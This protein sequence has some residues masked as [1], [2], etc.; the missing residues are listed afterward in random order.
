MKKFEFHIQRFA[1]T[2]TG[3][4]S[5]DYLSNYSDNVMMYAYG[6]ADTI[7]NY[8]DDVTISAG[9][10]NDTVI[11]GL[12]DYNSINAGAGNDVISLSSSQNWGW[13][14]TI[15]A[16]TGDDTIYANSLNSYYGDLYRYMSGDGN[17]IIY[18]FTDKDTIFI[19]GT[20]A[21]RSTVSGNVIL[22][23]ASGGAITLS[24]A[25]SKTFTVIDD[26][27]PL[28]IVNSTSHTVV[29]GTANADTITS[30][31]ASYVTI[32][33]GAGNDTI[34]NIYSGGGDYVSISGGNGDDYI[35]TYYSWHDT[36]SGDAGADTISIDRGRDNLING[37]AG[38]DKISLSN[39]SGAMTISGG[40]GNDTIYGDTVNVYGVLYNYA[41]GDGSD[42]M[43]NVS[44][45]DTISISGVSGENLWST[46]SSGSNVIVNVT[47]GGSMTL[48]GAVGKSLKI[49]PQN[50]GV[51]IVNSKA[52]TVINGTAYGDT[53]SNTGAYTKVYGNGGGDS[54]Y[55]TSASHVTLSGGA[56]NDTIQ[57]IYSGGGDYVS[58]SG[59]NGDDYI[60]TY[61]SWHDTI[62]GDAG[63]D[64]IHVSRGYDNV[65]DGGAG[66]DKISLS[67][68]SGKMT[69]RGGAGNDTIYGDTVNNYGVVYEYSTTSGNDVIY[70]FHANDTLSVN[71]ATYSTSTV[72]NDVLVSITGGGTI[73]LIGAKGIFN[74]G[75]TTFTEG[76]D[77]YSNTTSNTVLSALAGNDT[78][79]NSG[80]KVTL[81]AGTG[82]DKIYNNNGDS[83]SIDAGDGNDSIYAYDNDSV[84]IKAGAGSDTVN[85]SYYSSK[86]YGESGNDLM[87][88][89]GSGIS[90]LIDGGE[91]DDTIL[92]NGGTIYG[93]AGADSIS[94]SSGNYSGRIIN[95]GTGDDTIYGNSLSGY[96]AIYQYKYGDDNDVIKN[97]NAKD[98]ISIAGSSDYTTLKS[99]TNL[100]VS[101]IGSGAMTLSG[102]A[103]TT[104][105][106][107]GGHYIG[108][109]PTDGINVINST[110][111]VTITGTEYGDTIK[112][113][114]NR[115]GDYVVIEAGVGEDTIFNDYG[116]HLT[117]NAGAGDDT[118]TSYRGSS[119]SI[120]AGAGNDVISLS[121]SKGLTVVKGGTGNDIIYGDTVAHVYQYEN[122]DGDDV[123]YGYNAKDT[124]TISGGDYTRSTVGNDVII[125]VTDADSTVVTGSIT[126]SGAKG[127]AINI[128]GYI[129]P[130]PTTLTAQQVIK[131]FMG[132]LD[133]TSYSGI[134]A[135]NQAVS[136]ASNGYFTNAQAA[137]NQMVSDCQNND[138]NTFLQ[139]YCG[140][141]LNNSDTGAIT[142]SDAGGSATKTAT[143][144]VPESGS[145]N[146]FTGSS[147]TTNGLTVQLASYA[148]GNIF[149]PA[150]LSYS[151]LTD[152]TQKYI[153][154]A[155]QTW[156]V[157]G[158]LELISE[159]YG[160]NF[161]FSSDSSA[162][163]KKM[164][165][166]F[167]RK[168][169]GTMAVTGWYSNY[170]GQATQLSMAVNMRNYDTLINGSMD[171]KLSDSDGYYLDRVL[172]HE[173]THAVMVANINYMAD[174]PDFIVEGMAELTHGTDDD[175]ASEISY[176]ANSPTALRN[177]L[178]LYQGSYDSY[179]GG[180]MFLR[181]LAKQSA[182]NAGSDSGNMSA[183]VSSSNN[184]SSSNIT[185]QRD[186]TIKSGVLTAAK[187]FDEDMIDLSTYSSTVTKVNASN[188]TNGVMIIGNTRNNSIKAGKG[189]DTISGNT[190]NDSIFGGNGNDVIYGD[191]GNDVIKGEAGNDTLSGG[192]GK[193]TLYGGAG[194][195]VFVHLAENDFIADYVAGQDKIKLVEG[196]ILSASVSGSNIVLGTSTG[197]IT[198]K[199]GKGK[200]ITVIDEE[201]NET[202]QIYTNNFGSEGSSDSAPTGVSVKSGILTAN[203]TFTGS[204]ID[205]TATYASTVTKVNATAL[206][207][208]VN[209]IGNSSANSI[210]S[211]KG[212]D[213]I[214]GAA[215]KD[216]I[217]GGAGNDVLYG[218]ADNDILKGEAG[219]DTLYGGAGNDTL[220]G[221]AGNDVFVYESGNDYIADYAVGDKIKLVDSAITSSSISGSNV[222]LTVDSGTITLKGGKGKNVTVIDSDGNS[223]TRKYTNETFDRASSADLFEDSNF[224]T[225][226]TKLEDITAISADNYSAGK[227]ETVNYGT[228]AQD[229]NQ[230]YITYSSNK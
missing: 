142:G 18:G 87:S 115:G 154:Q 159:S 216:S 179:A 182:E 106:V 140:I 107:K 136:V 202:T 181:Y 60:Y 193:D 203:K 113:I 188:L 218:G 38:N 171:G 195:D 185:S 44:A 47:G 164:Y 217:L 62:S 219:A 89:S 34:Q 222:I 1:T 7:Y 22:N 65:I 81:N 13:R 197:S 174:L 66:D 97:Y 48:V 17:D 50:I 208:A 23:M 215:G 161:G 24:G 67:S 84:T 95:G 30:S 152:N 130:E 74:P 138:S 94:L 128:N 204:T 86:I 78:I 46:V 134:A 141:I 32:S 127:K 170:T 223:T 71:G 56:G 207:Q 206:S 53:I 35:Y 176:L 14:T 99:G 39:N 105:N 198:V 145:L 191:A 68:N 139:D 5:N 178:S 6:G 157:D 119:N 177:A 9:E 192:A 33:G 83:S 221:G 227:F 175:R 37:G 28:P 90:N 79:I 112:N 41:V 124:I 137:I 199:G 121:G 162:T 63:A 205:L 27:T 104:L 189:A 15:N 3:T 80:Q 20:T 8:G 160:D 101:V 70:N 110:S 230:N 133:T 10:G 125:N 228:L 114:Y 19:S 214:S 49:Y 51:N 108:P 116:Y 77:Y 21:T 220:Y 4:A 143:S 226:D 75:S 209:I 173:F 166:G 184:S 57:N 211:G 187:T 150:N 85:G 58:I 25:S 73:S 149:N 194:N 167:I 186:V 117:I 225:N 212:A 148:G 169:S 163:V 42:V 147:F 96:G 43:Y 168:N 93:G 120:N 98:T 118:V 144:I 129:P 29:N 76:D 40:A 64:T 132:A 72:G 201:D 61:Y 102:A 111:Y 91:G 190:G 82:N 210:K 153:W 36:I 165:F 158:A 156:W 16:G 200:N 183:M 59:G 196:N 229:E 11:R 126:L 131:N 146:S 103:N 109:N 122:G 123:I 100:I 31:G 172:A 224:M 55:N 26:D 52:D 12:A 135:L 45:N 54:I 155:F 151:S 213:T 88:I 180:Y 69:I 92:A 2:M